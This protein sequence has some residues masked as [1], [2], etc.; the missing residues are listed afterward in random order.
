MD[1]ATVTIIRL[2]VPLAIFGAPL[3]AFLVAAHID[4]LDWGWLDMPNRPDDEAF[5]QSWDKT[6]DTYHLLLAA[7]VA[8]SWKDRTARRLA[9]AAFAYRTFGTALF[10]Q[11]SNPL[12]LLIFPNVLERIF[13][14][15][16]IYRLVSR[17]DQLFT[18]P[19]S[20][21]LVLVAVA[22]PKASEEYMIHF[23]GARP[24][25]SFSVLPDPISYERTE[26]YFWSAIILT[27]PALAMTRLLLELNKLPS[28][29]A[30]VL[31]MS[32]VDRV[33]GR[34][35]FAPELLGLAHAYAVSL[36]RAVLQR[37][38]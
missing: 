38:N 16:L 2:I 7:I 5:Y 26:Y 14:F 31:D 1:F 4:K 10:L 27:M 37:R 36:P 34:T 12:F 6:M 22:I 9:L 11:T 28:H 15:Y 13:L 3:P 33:C 8:T 18:G 23:I 24:W 30:P 32:P 20:V 19:A 25:Q 21:A 29:V 17:R 35:G